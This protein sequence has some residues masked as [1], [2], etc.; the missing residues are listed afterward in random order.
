MEFQSTMSEADSKIFRRIHLYFL[1][2]LQ[3]HRQRDSYNRS[4]IY[5]DYKEYLIISMSRIF[6]R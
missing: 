5:D 4:N 2:V 1:Y 3:M 6:S